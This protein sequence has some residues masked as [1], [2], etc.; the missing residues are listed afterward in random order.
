LLLKAFSI[1]EKTPDVQSAIIKLRDLLNVDHVVYHFTN[2]RDPKDLRI[3]PT[4]PPSWIDRYVKM[5]LL[6]IDP[7]VREGFRRTRPFDWNEVRKDDPA[8]TLFWERAFEEGVGRRGLSI[9][10]R[11][12]GGQLALFSI[13]SSS[14]SDDEW[15]DFVRATLPTLIRIANR[16]N[17]KILSQRPY[18]TATELECLRLNALG[19]NRREIATILG[20]SAST[21]RDYLASASHKLDAATSVQAAS[22]A[23][24]LGL[25][26][27][28]KPGDG[29][30]SSKKRRLRSTSRSSNNRRRRST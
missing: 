6:G 1:I 22:Q 8:E 24:K 3:H 26:A 5:G 19:K 21:A 17:Q 20:L 13:S 7:V 12:K 30:S 23:V 14:R 9:P 15:E 4:Y 2:P 25:F 27:P 10:I 11:S 29:R 18:L 16:L 28:L